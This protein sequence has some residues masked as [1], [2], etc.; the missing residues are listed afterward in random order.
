MHSATRRLRVDL[1]V[2]SRLAWGE[3]RW[4]RPHH[5]EHR[6]RDALWRQQRRDRPPPAGRLVAID[7]QARVLRLVGIDT[8]IAI[9]QA[10]GATQPLDLLVLPGEK[11]PTRLRSIA[12]RIL[13]EDVRC[14]RLRV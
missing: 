9:I 4:L 14:I 11:G 10:E 8:G 6:S 5:P 7:N 12:F 1:W 2:P 13:L 3:H